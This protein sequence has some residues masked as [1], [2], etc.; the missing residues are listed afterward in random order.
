MIILTVISLTIM[1]AFAHSLPTVT[2]PLS[3][4]LQHNQG[5]LMAALKAFTNTPHLKEELNEEIGRNIIYFLSSFRMTLVCLL[6][7]FQ[8]LTILFL[9]YCV[10]LILQWLPR[11]F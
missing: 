8:L 1:A 6:C 9:G 7:M 4:Q 2:L 11:T 3:N 10:H 5:P